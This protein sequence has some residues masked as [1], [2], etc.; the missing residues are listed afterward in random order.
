MKSSG[1]VIQLSDLLAS[2]RFIR[3]IRGQLPDSVQKPFQDESLA[4][5]QTKSALTA[6]RPPVH[7]RFCPPRPTHAVCRLELSQYPHTLHQAYFNMCPVQPDLR[8]ETK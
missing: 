3:A 7:P 8:P 4:L 2:I 5:K 1:S 6:Q